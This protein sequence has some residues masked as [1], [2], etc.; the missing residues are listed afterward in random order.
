MDRRAK[1]GGRAA[2]VAT[3]HEARPI[4]GES[5]DAA[6]PAPQWSERS[7]DD[8]LALDLRM[9][10]WHFRGTAPRFVWTPVPTLKTCV[11]NAFAPRDHV[12]WSLSPYRHL[13]RAELAFVLETLGE[14]EVKRGLGAMQREV[15]QRL[16]HVPIWERFGLLTAAFQ[17][18]FHYSDSPDAMHL[19]SGRHF[20][21]AVP[22]R[23]RGAVQAHFM[24]Q[25]RD[26]GALGVVPCKE[27]VFLSANRGIVND[28]S[29]PL[30]GL[31]V[32]RLDVAK[33]ARL[34]EEIRRVGDRLARRFTPE[35]IGWLYA[36]SGNVCLLP[37]P[38][39]A[40]TQP[41]RACLEILRFRARVA[42]VLCR[43]PLLDRLREDLEHPRW[44]AWPR[45]RAELAA[46]LHARLAPYAF[47]TDNPFE[48]PPPDARPSARDDD[49]EP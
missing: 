32:E 31:P 38:E 16:H 10:F 22:V 6:V 18:Y 9:A 39:G 29:F 21:L 7:I 26:L 1:T 49:D 11:L 28:P 27:T 34:I 25:W 40:E 23:R 20:S 36:Y 41:L 47:V 3:R 46:L 13:R 12:F 15:H 2:I 17:G 48:P 43:L 37:P 19:R 44:R 4:V 5:H 42:C 14:R 24:Q 30:L 35:T 45:Q 33:R 8:L